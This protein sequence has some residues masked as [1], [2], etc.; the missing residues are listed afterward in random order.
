MEM[1]YRNP[2]FTSKE[3]IVGPYRFSIA[4]PR[5]PMKLS[6]W[7]F[8]YWFYVLDVRGRKKSIGLRLLGINFQITW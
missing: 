1:K 4:T 2:Q 3:F 8:N 7:G 5:R 6:S